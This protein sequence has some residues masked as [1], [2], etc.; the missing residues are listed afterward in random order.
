MTTIASPTRPPT[1][2]WLDLDAAGQR[3][4]ASFLQGLHKA[5]TVDELGFGGVRQVYSSLLFPATNTQMRRAV[6]YL[7][8]PAL[9]HRLHGGA[10]IGHQAEH[11]LEQLENSLRRA[12]EKHAHTND[13][14]TEGIIGISSR[15]KLK[16]YPSSLYWWP[17]YELRILRKSITRGTWAQGLGQWSRGDHIVKDDDGTNHLDD[18]GTLVWDGRALRVSPLE[19][20]VVPEELDPALKYEAAVYLRQCFLDIDR[21]RRFTS[22]MGHLVDK[23]EEASFGQ[24]WDAPSKPKELRRY[25]DDARRYSLFARG[26][27][28]HYNHLVT[29]TKH[30]RVATVADADCW[31]PA[32]EHWWDRARADLAGWD[33]AAYKERLI[34]CSARIESSVPSIV[35]CGKWLE[36]LLATDSSEAFLADRAARNIVRAQ[37]ADN[38][39]SRARLIYTDRLHGWAETEGANNRWPYHLHYRAPRACM[40]LNDI[41]A[42]LAGES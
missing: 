21:R 23:R 7:T 2:G 10:T 8:T 27:T 41:V 16:R 18:D 37:E 25:V 5:G 24:A 30:E 38:K 9:C 13:L 26:A 40:V 22:L 14:P 34:V 36:R 15:D 11:E 1:I 29:R 3:A 33:L 28:L 35:F 12:F 20:G 32:F 17:M 39:Q 31:V 19:D 4:A 42:G 6:Y